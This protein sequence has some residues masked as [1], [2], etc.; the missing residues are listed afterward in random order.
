MGKKV[1]G[2]SVIFA[3]MLRSMKFETTIAASCHNMLSLHSSSNSTLRPQLDHLHLD[4]RLVRHRH[5]TLRLVVLCAHCPL[6]PWLRWLPLQADLLTTLLRLAPLLCVVLDSGQ[7]RLARLGVSDVFNADVDALLD[8]S[9]ANLL[10][11]DDANCAL[12]DV[13]DDASLAVVDFV[14]LEWCQSRPRMRSMLAGQPA[15]VSTGNSQL[16]SLTMPFW[17]APF[18]TTSTTSPTLYCLRYVDSGIIPRC[19]NLR[20]KAVVHGQPL[21]SWYRF[22]LAKSLSLSIPS[23][24]G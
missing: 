6:A 4:R 23:G 12:G 11:E 7:E 1:V 22:F 13:V 10:V 8:V 24:V 14:R 19:L 21:S 2:R 20:E 9:V 17:T 3:C 16:W 18:A 5:N 15:V